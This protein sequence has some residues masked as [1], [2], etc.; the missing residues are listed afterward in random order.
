M[1][2][3]TIKVDTLEH[4]SAGSVDTKY[5]INSSAKAWVYYDN[6]S[7][8]VTR[9]SFLISSVVDNGTGDATIT[10]SNAM[11]DAFSCIAGLTGFSTSDPNTRFESGCIPSSTTVR[12][13]Q[14]TH[15]G[16]NADQDCN[17][18]CIIGD[19]A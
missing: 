16:S 14:I 15:S 10:L 7:S 9:G 6:L 12:L 1:S 4:S 17:H 18:M 3:G 5:M 11:T 13:E 2:L 19:L 8:N